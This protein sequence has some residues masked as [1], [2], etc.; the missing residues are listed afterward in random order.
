MCVLRE[1]ILRIV[2]RPEQETFW[3]TFLR[4]QSAWAFRGEAGH[5][6]RPHGPEESDQHR[7][8]GRCLVALPVHFLPNV[9]GV[10]PKNNES[11]ERSNAATSPPPHHQPRG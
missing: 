2:V 1:E 3:T 10:I 8:P 5:H 6:R 9:L 4:P 11:A 7:V